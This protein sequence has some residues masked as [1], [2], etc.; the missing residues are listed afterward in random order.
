M[1]GPSKIREVGRPLTGLRRL[2]PSLLPAIS[3]P[4]Y[5][6]LSHGSLSVSIEGMPACNLANELLSIAISFSIL[7][8][9]WY[10][11]YHNQSRR[12]MILG[13][14]FLLGGILR[15]ARFASYY[16]FL[17][18]LGYGKVV[19]WVQAGFLLA[20]SLPEMTKP[21]RP[22]DRARAMGLG[23]LLTAGLFLCQRPSLNHCHLLLLIPALVH[24]GVDFFRY[25]RDQLFIGAVLLAASQLTFARLG[26]LSILECWLSFLA[27][28]VFYKVLVLDLPEDEAAPLYKLYQGTESRELREMGHETKN[29]LTALRAIAQF[30]QSMLETTPKNKELYARIIAEIDQLSSLINFT[31][32]RHK[33]DLV[34]VEEDLTNLLKD[35]VDLFRAKIEMAGINVSCSF[36]REVP[37]VPIY[38]QLLR[39]ALLNV[40]QNAVQAMPA[41]GDLQISLIPRRKSVTIITKDTGCGMSP[42]ILRRAFEPFFTTKETGTGLGLAITRQI[43]EEVH[44][45][46]L[47]MK[48]R[49][50]RGTT[51]S[52][53]LPLPDQSTFIR[54]NQEAM[55]ELPA[56]NPEPPPEQGQGRPQAASNS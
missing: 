36:P 43:I 54:I 16:G 27:H 51:F 15:M 52:L 37:L 41:G 4:L 44:Q 2:I 55:S 17:R 33:P 24:L 30:G 8:V 50:G 48:S 32:A 39:Q 26:P 9:T 18:P 12:H 6:H 35:L 5:L 13:L 1:D 56:K 46:K 25:E 45:G 40:I 14:G 28:L 20:A 19:Y 23:F 10:K 38:P 42:H 49:K 53:E 11:N 29:V 21:Y 7:S 31:L 47:R 3:L 22:E 34:K